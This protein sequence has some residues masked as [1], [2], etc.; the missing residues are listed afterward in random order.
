[1][2]LKMFRFNSTANYKRTSLCVTESNDILSLYLN[3]D[4]ELRAIFFKNTNLISLTEESLINDNSYLISD[5]INNNHYFSCFHLFEE[6]IT[7]I[8][9]KENQ[10]FLSIKTVNS[11]NM[12]VNYNDDFNNMAINEE[13]KYQI[14]PFYYGNEA[15][16]MNNKKFVIFSKYENNEKL[17]IILCE[18]YNQKDNIYKSINVRYYELS[19]IDNDIEFN[20]FYLFLFNGL[21]GI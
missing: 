1:M 7:I 10:L 5:T 13:N 17:L 16:K 20:Q 6:T 4:H 14:S 8:F 18:L 12:L 9:F 21:F 11:N 15:I 19:L 3:N 2:D